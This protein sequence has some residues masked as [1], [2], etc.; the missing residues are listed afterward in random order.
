MRITVKHKKVIEL[1]IEGDLTKE[2]IAKSVHIARSTLYKWLEDEEFKEEYDEQLA[3]IERRI[4][5][6]INNMTKSALDRQEKILQKGKNDI[7]AAA[8]A[9]DVLDRAGYA[10]EDNINI[11]GDNVVQIINDIPRSDGGD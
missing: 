11:R 1:L 8:V 7:A 4:R 6:R 9:K 5:R 3:E 10:A 2:E